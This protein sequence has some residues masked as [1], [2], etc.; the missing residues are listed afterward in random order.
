[1]IQNTHLVQDDKQIQIVPITTYLIILA[2]H[3][4]ML[5][6]IKVKILMLIKWS[7]GSPQSC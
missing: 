2:V 4:N 6:T 3:M 5:S 1:M 7:Y